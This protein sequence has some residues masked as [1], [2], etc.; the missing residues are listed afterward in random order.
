MTSEYHGTVSGT[1]SPTLSARH[2]H[3]L[4]VGPAIYPYMKR[5][6]LSYA[7]KGIAVFP[8]KVSDK[9]PLTGKGGFHH[10]T[11]DPEQIAA[12]W[13]KHPDAAI[14][15]PTGMVN[16]WV[17]ADM[18]QDTHEALKLWHGLPETLTAKT[19]RASGV[20]R[21]RYFAID[22]P[23]ASTKL[24]GGAIDLKADGG[25]IILPPSKHASGNRYEWLHRAPL[26]DLPE[27]L[28]SGPQEKETSGP[29]QPRPERRYTDDGGPIPRGQ[30]DDAL[31]SI[32]GLLRSQGYEQDEILDELLAINE[33]RCEPPKKPSAVR[34]IARSVSR[35]PK[36]K[37]SRRDERTRTP[38]DEARRDWWHSRWR[39]K[40]DRSIVHVL[41]SEARQHGTLTRDGGVDISISYRVVAV[42]AAVSLRTVRKS[43]DRLRG[44]WVR[45]GSRGSGTQ[46]GSFVLLPREQVP[47]SDHHR[48]RCIEDV[49][50]VVPPRTPRLMHSAVLPVM[51]R[52]VRVDTIVIRRL[53]KVC[54]HIIDL[55]D[56]H[57]LSVSLEDI[58]QALGTKRTRDLTRY[59]KVGDRV[60]FEGPVA[61]LKNRGIVTVDD[62]VVHLVKDWQEALETERTVTG[63]KFAEAY[64]T[65]RY[66]EQRE[67]YRGRHKIKAHRF[68]MGEMWDRLPRPTSELTRLPDPHPELV[69]VFKLWA[70]SR[71]LALKDYPLRIAATVWAYDLVSF[72]PTALQVEAALYEVLGAKA[73]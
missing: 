20:G 11:T 5:W 49:A 17:V 33:T 12:W 37:M 47:H 71:P 24:A 16:G 13:D 1:K 32:G 41:I 2:R 43:I 14:G 68:S 10:A 7:Q 25:Y 53:G 18:D 61:R 63:E 34:R 28:L 58:A 26:A 9:A 8:C 27:E 65:K 38:L 59:S 6:A 3:I 42:K 50:S 73:A 62:G 15:A 55:L 45:P 19:G 48:V 54:E 69:T 31:A 60:T 22:E 51:R 67:A 39:N 40:S 44:E 56:A 66:R 64:W 70:E 29:R 21:H 30:R 52:G 4:E 36:G 72:K 46:S 23:V 35:Y 57:G